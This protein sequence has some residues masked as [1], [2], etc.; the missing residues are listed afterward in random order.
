MRHN[1]IVQ[2]IEQLDAIDFY[3]RVMFHCGICNKEVLDNMLV[4]DKLLRRLEKLDLDAYIC[5]ITD[6]RDVIEKYYSRK[7]D[8]NECSSVPN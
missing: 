4:Q 2:T 1:L 8:Q 3:D 6:E 5:Y 7:A